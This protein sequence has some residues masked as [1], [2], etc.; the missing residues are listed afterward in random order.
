MLLLMRVLWVAVWWRQEKNYKWR[1]GLLSTLFA[2]GLDYCT[3][4]YSIF[5]E[6]TVARE[7]F[8]KLAW[9]CKKK[10]VACLYTFR[11]DDVFFG[12]DAQVA[13][14]GWGNSTIRFWGHMG[15]NTWYL[16]PGTRYF[17]ESRN[18][19]KSKIRFGSAIFNAHIR[20]N[21]YVLT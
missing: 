18:Y 12:N 17:Y 19:N 4:W 14:Y 11:I 5:W 15:I 7:H 13:L 1:T 16:Y 21:L 8:W 3:C 10:G 9:L 6:T 2:D 20:V